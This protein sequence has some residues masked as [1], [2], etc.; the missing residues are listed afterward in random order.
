MSDTELLLLQIK[1]AGL[2]EPI[3]EYPFAK[4]LGRRYKSDMCFFSQKLLVEIEGGIFS[5]QAHGSITG[6]KRDIEKYNLAVTL[7]WKVIR[8][9]PEWIETGYALEL[10][11]KALYPLP[12]TTKPLMK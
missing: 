6:I 9:L 10:I 12:I 2:P 5:R 7:G 11:Q 8:L 4:Q 3:L 1:A